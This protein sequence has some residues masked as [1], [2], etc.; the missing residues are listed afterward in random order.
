MGKQVVF[1][2]TAANDGTGD[3]LRLGAQKINENFTELY[4]ALGDGSTLASGNYVTTSANQVLANKTIDGSTNT[5]TNIPSSA[6]STLPNSKLDNSSIT[7]GD[8]TSTNFNVDLGGSFEI[9][10]GSGINTAI[11]NNRI[12]LSTD[13][14][15]VT[16]S[17]TD[18][19]T[20][21]T[22]SGATNTF[23]QIPNSA[24]DNNSISIG[25]V[26]LALG[27]TDATPALNLSDAN[28][29]PTTALSG[30]IENAQLTGNI[31]NDKLVN[32]SIRIGDNTST[33]LDINLGESLEIVGTS[34]VTSTLNGNRL[35]LSL[36]TIGNSGLTNSSFTIGTD[37]ISLGGSITSIAGLSLTGNTTVDLTGAGS[38]LRFDFAGYGSL[39]AFGS[40][41][42]MFAFDTVGNRPY[43]SSGSGWVRI[44]DEN[45]SVSA[46]TDVNTTG[47]ADG[48]VLAWSS[49]QGRF[50]ATAPTSGSP[51]TIAD[52]GGDLS[53]AATKLDFVGAGVTASGTGSTKTITI[54]GGSGETLTVE[55]EGS[56][57]STTATTMDFVGKTITASGSG[58]EKTIDVRHT[59]TILDVTANGSSAYRFS[60][61]YGTEDNPTIYTKQGQTIAFN[62]SGLAGSHPFVLQNISGA[63]SSGNRISDGLTH[64][65]SDG[66]VT[67]G[68]SAQ[69]K[70]NGVLYWDVPH[71]SATIYYVC[72]S[73]GAMNGTLEVAKKEGGKLLQQVNT[74]TGAVATGTTIFP[75]DDSI[76]QNTEGDEYMT[77]SITPKSATSTIMIEAHIFYSQSAGTRSGAGLF[78]DSDAD[79]LSFTSNFVYDATSMS[80][81]QVFYSETSGNTTARTYKIR[82]GILQTSGTFT[83]NGQSGNRKFGGTTLSTIRILEIA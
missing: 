38:K 5:I 26:S 51:L 18:T 8:D 69:G 19:L 27:A 31:T 13:G 61:H 50:N 6:L 60:S 33:S 37:S 17:S 78:K 58:A 76:P 16:E 41:T 44:L 56:A 49:A 67:T 3:N 57:L 79:A 12:E 7:I 9:V 2:G 21:K 82:C 4:T 55:D 34:P 39:P 25:G 20:N 62:L 14:S 59:T 75:E 40:Y 47:I 74:Q 73:H 53:T 11:T 29:Y 77:L 52:E 35:E 72:S 42:G 43:Y 54:A 36:G 46:H 24:L 30:T 15:I 65:A 45:A 66:T 1:R 71:D 68:L 48:N 10:G 63:Y 81:M 83:F 22:I 80:N 64:V 70:T 23:N 28:S 32:K